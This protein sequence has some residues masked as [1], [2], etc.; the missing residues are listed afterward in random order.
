MTTAPQARPTPVWPIALFILL[1]L[2]YGIWQAG[3]ALS[4][5]LRG[6]DDMMRMQQI[7]DLIAGQSWFDVDQS[8]LDT[9][10]GGAMHWSRLPDLV[11][12]AIVF[13]FQPLIGRE[14]AEGIAITAWPLMLMV[15]VLTALVVCLRRL[16]AP[17]SGQLAGI[18]FFSTSAAMVNVMP[19]RIDHHGLGL[20][21]ILTGFAAL[22]SPRP[23]PRSGAVGAVCVAA[24]LSVAMENLPAAG[25]LIAGFG[26]AWIFRGAAEANRLRAFGASLII[27]ALVTFVFDAPGGGG[28]RD[29]CDAYGQSHF[30]ALLVAG[31]SLVLIATALPRAES[32][33]TRL[34]AMAVAGGLTLIGFIAVN[35]SC[36]GDPYAALP[37]LVRDGWLDVVAEARPLPRVIAEDAALAVFFYGFAFAGLACAWFAVRIGQSGKRLEAGALAVL[38]T[39]SVALMVWQLRAASLA[40]ALAAIASGWMFGYLFANWQS[41]RGAGPA[42]LLLVGAVFISPSGWAYARSLMP[43][44]A[45]DARSFSAACRSGEAYR[46]VAAAPR[47]VVFTPV[48]LGAPLIYYTRHLATSAPYHRN[49][50]AIELTFDVFRGTAETARRKI[51]MTG[52]THLLYCPGLGELSRHARAAPDGFAADL[53]NGNLP[54]WL[55]PLTR[56]EGEEEGPVLYTISF[57]RN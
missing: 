3:P 52:A 42:L 37:P 25:M 18:F 34:I 17:V 31:G 38:L 13:L 15:W 32:W 27:A 7:R 21:L 35:P 33:R 55:T 1:A 40:H 26:A 2:A 49:P 12:A 53:I 45:A 48:D 5:D 19:G 20:A 14:L 47:A 28:Q 54:S 57:D 22:L 10:E 16:G 8:R 41:K 4:G 23:L 29:V 36:I 11:P 43:D 9:P 30:V 46:P 50:A 44:G 39:I 56:I 51:A 24:M 6:S